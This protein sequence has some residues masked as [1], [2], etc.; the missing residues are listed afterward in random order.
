MK[1]KN[2][3]EVPSCEEKLQICQ[4]RLQTARSS[5][6][7]SSN[8]LGGVLSILKTEKRNFAKLENGFLMEKTIDNL[9]DDCEKAWRDASNDIA[10]K[11]LDDGNSEP[12]PKSK[13]QLCRIIGVLCEE[14]LQK[15]LT[16]KAS[17]DAQNIEK[18]LSLSGKELPGKVA[19]L[20]EYLAIA[21]SLNI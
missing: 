15:G 3:E 4:E 8:A 2:I 7:I 17:T 19:T 13:N 1:D 21:N 5:R 20:A 11:T 16:G 9:I 10:N 14:L 12:P 18:K 6:D